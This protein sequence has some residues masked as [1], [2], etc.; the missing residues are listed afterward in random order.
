MERLREQKIGLSLL[1][2]ELLAIRVCRVWEEAEPAKPHLAVPAAHQP[3][4][5]LHI[6][7]AP[8]GPPLFVI[9]SLLL[10][11]CFRTLTRTGDES[12]HALT[13]LVF[14]RTRVLERIVALRLRRQSVA[15]AEASNESLASELLRL[16]DF[17]ML[18]LAY[19]HSHPAYGPSATVPSSTDRQTQDAMEKSGSQILGGIFSRDGFVRF[20][21][22]RAEPN[23][24]VVGKRVREI[25]RNV[26]HLETEEDL[27]E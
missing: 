17:G 26:Y 10:H 8:V 3:V 13:G 27:Q 14:R 18:P 12:L 6:P 25:E 11:E 20:Y 9:S 15:G 24:R 1:G 7:C 5:R 23:V 16:Y 22:N 2:H 19:F 21:A 4:R